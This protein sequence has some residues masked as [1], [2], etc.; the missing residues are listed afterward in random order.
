MSL[1]DALLL[2][3]VRINV[4]IA[5]RSDGIAATSQGAFHEWS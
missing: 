3:P 5:K 2:D 4:W 1:L